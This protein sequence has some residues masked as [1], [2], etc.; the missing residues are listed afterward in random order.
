MV[1][2]TR[3]MTEDAAMVAAARAGDEAA[4]SGLSERYRRELRVHC[5]RMLGSFE[6]AEDLVQ[7]TFLRAWRARESFEG[8]SS[9]RA[10]LYGIATNGCLDFLQRNP[11]RAQAKAEGPPG[12]GR[13]DP[14]A[15][16]EV[17]W[18]QPFPDRLLEPAAPAADHPDAA[19][20]KKETIG[21]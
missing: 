19:V 20:F 3:A 15:P 14:A 8:R 4:F 6:D 1:N 12:A 10:W 5:Y 18:L 11:Q 9:L 7:E 17:A 13:T 21:L 2:E 16:A